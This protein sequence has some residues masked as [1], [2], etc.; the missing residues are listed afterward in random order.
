MGAPVRR[1][2]VDILS[3]VTRGGPTLAER[4]AHS[5]V[6]ALPP[7]DRA[8]LHELVLGTLR[9]RGGLDHALKACLDAP[10]GSLD[11][12]LRT[13]LRMGAYQ[14]LHLRVPA[15]AAVFESV[16]LARQIAPRVA[17]LVNAVLRRLSREGPPEFPEPKRDPLAW[18]TTE[19]SLPA[20]LAKRWIDHLGPDR[21]VLRARSF[22]EAP[23]L[24]FRLNP[25]MPDAWDK[26][27]AA[28]L[29]PRPLPVPG[30]WLGQRVPI[31]PLLREAVLYLQDQGSQLVAHLAATPGILLDAC[32][33]P[34]GKTTLLAD[35]L[36]DKG[37]VVAADAS[38]RRVRLLNGLVARW[39]CRNVRVV[40][41]DAH[42]PPF[43]EGF[44]SILL[45]APCTGLG[46]LGRHPDIRW[47]SRAEDLQRQSHRQGALLASL[48]KLVKK[49]GRLVYAT[50]SS[51]P[52][53]N[54]EVV[55]HFLASHS[56]FVLAPLPPWA[57]V[58]AS[59]DFA[60]TNP[61]R[62]RGDAFSGAILERQ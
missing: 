40:A 61:E 36:D 19:G 27:T 21:A 41:A 49:G 32:A 8:F 3:S 18:L 53:E 13:I 7:R 50:C 26:V 20:W 5:D 1:L 58:F 10:L 25:R 17:G 42:R 47:R 57:G 62:D 51:E 11:S 38:V 2:A 44:H 16:E 24:V 43:R 28:G 37:W 60:R 52:E 6:E 31:Q 54:D 33:S 45:D 34:G 30:A 4:L 14:L 22:L 35:L 9:M 29:E 39:G 23:P 15:R 48:A 12:R 56:E 59:G 55:R 46:T